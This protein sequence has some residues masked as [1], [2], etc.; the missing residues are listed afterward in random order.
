MQNSNLPT[1]FAIPFANNAG[2]S[3]IR[4]IPQSSQQGITPGA[5]SL[6]DGFPPICFIPT[7]SNGIPPAGQDING[8]LQQITAWNRWQAAGGTVSF[9][10][11]F[12]ASI[13][14]YPYGA[15]IQSTTSGV[16]WLNTVD[17]NTTNPDSGSA[18]G[19]IQ[20]VTGNVLTS[21]SIVGGNYA[22]YSNPGTYTWSVPTGV[23]KIRLRIW[24]GGGGGGAGS[25]SSSGGSGG[26]GGGYGEGTYTIASGTTSLAV[27]VGAGGAAGVASTTSP[28]SGG[29][30]GTSSVG[31][32]LSVTGGQGG[33]AGNGG[34]ATQLSNSGSATG[35]QLGVPGYFGGLAYTLQGVVIGG[36]GG[37]AFGT[38]QPPVNVAPAGGNPGMFPGGGAGGAAGYAGGGLGAPGFVIIEY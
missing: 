12:A 4:P 11:T 3:Y 6:A 22:S 36:S 31:S 1:K 30:G 27:I 28:S 32:F 29:T 5:A 16:L 34:T 20:V 19:W 33:Q 8:I 18:S 10:A 9:D 38:S 13:A 26:G 14:G 15:V 24:G 23:T 37:A 2:S 17:G 21:R 7:T 35:S 25:S